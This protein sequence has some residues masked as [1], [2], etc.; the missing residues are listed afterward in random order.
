MNYY[1]LTPLEPL[2]F[3]DG[4]PLDRQR[5]ELWPIPATVAAALNVRADE[6][7][8]DPGEGA[9]LEDVRKA[10]PDSALWGPLLYDPT[11]GLLLPPPADMLTMEAP[12]SAI[13]QEKASLT[14]IRGE[15][16]D[17]SRLYWPT[18]Q[19]L[20]RVLKLPERGPD[21][22][23]YRPVEDALPWETQLRWA[24]GQPLPLLF[25]PLKKVYKQAPRLHVGI[26][27]T[28]G[29]AEPGILFRTTG[30]SLRPELGYVV[31]WQGPPILKKGEKEVVIPLGGEGRMARLESL[32]GYQPPQPTAATDALPT[33]PGF[34][35]LQLLTPGWFQ[36]DP[37][38]PFQPHL[39]ELGLVAMR[40]D[41]FRSFSGWQHRRNPKTGLTEQQPRDVRRG[42][43]GGAGY[44]Y[45][46]TDGKVLS[47]E[48][49]RDW[50]QNLW[51]QPIE[52]LNNS[53]NQRNLPSHL[54][55]GLCLPGYTPF[56]DESS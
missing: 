2:V 36:H 4:R 19:P 25:S 40:T 11:E 41:R 54:G 38:A 8:S 9:K 24:M 48:Q 15:L 10:L 17:G 35:R 6:V 21:G 47:A 39:P 1:R 50:I 51:L 3:G 56:G 20:P 16:I 43:P 49:L 27:A 23:K 13:V 55:F 29:T 53:L 18:G 30:V 45:G 31:G 52:K 14:A 34:L 12:T 32:E 46:T 33:R 5:G 7:A 37:T 22:T 42:V 44:W 28:K 26:D